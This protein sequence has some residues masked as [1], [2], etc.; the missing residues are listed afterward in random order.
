LGDKPFFPPNGEISANLVAL[1]KGRRGQ[2][3]D[4]TLSFAFATK[5]N[6]SS[7]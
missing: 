6:L 7:S 1:S 4:A 5:K 2:Q 3:P